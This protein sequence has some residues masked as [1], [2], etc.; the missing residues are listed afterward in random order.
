LKTLDESFLDQLVDEWPE[1][2]GPEIEIPDMPIIRRI[3]RARGQLEP[4]A[5]TSPPVKPREPVEKAP[6]KAGSAETPRPA[7]TGTSPEPAGD[8]PEPKA[9][10]DSA[11]ARSG[12]RRRRRRKPTGEGRSAQTET[13]TVSDQTPETVD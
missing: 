12:K 11:E 9:D 10:A 8:A 7:G 5:L 2:L 1:R 6:A 3:K 13:E 4:A